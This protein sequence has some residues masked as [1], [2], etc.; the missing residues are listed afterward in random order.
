MN[1]GAERIITRLNLAPLPVEGGYFRRTWLSTELRPDGRAAG[2]QIWYLLTTD[3]FSALHRLDA[4]ERWNFQAGD[5]IEHVQLDPR[6]GSVR[7]QTLGQGTH[8]SL[9][10]PAG[11]WQGARPAAC[12]HPRGWSL[13]ACSMSPAWDETGFEPG[14]R[15]ELLPVFP[16]AMAL[17]GALTH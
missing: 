11:V 14:R 10:V 17:I 7:I 1:V 2:S 4:P 5:P 8:R 9:T 16:A 6:D 3:S 12:L 15:A 13:L